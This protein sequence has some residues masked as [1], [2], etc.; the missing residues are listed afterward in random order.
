ML[1]TR[2]GSFSPAGL[3]ALD[4]WV[5]NGIVGRT[6]SG[7][8]MSAHIIHTKRNGE[9]ATTTTQ[10]IDRIVDELRDEPRIVVHFHGG[11]VDDEIGMR[12][13][14]R[15][16][17]TY[18]AAGASPIFFVWSSGLMEVVTG[19]LPE[20]FGEG[21]F[22]SI[23][24]WVTKFVLG[25]ASQAHGFAPPS[26]AD[27]WL[28]LVP[29]EPEAEALADVDVL[30]D[31]DEVS[32]EERAAFEQEVASDPELQAFSAMIAASPASLAEDEGSPFTLMTP[33][34]VG[35]IRSDAPTGAAFGPFQAVALARRAGKVVVAVV[36][37]LREHRD[38]GLYPTIIEEILRA[39]YLGQA[40]ER[41]WTAMKKE[42]ADTFEATDPVRG[43]RYFMDKLSDLVRDGHRPEITLVGH[44]T[45]AVF[46][47]N[48]L[49]RM[50]RMRSDPNDPF[51]S[52]FRV[53]NVVFLAPACR[54]EHFDNV[55]RARESTFDRFRMFTMSDEFEAKDTL[56][57]F[58]YPRSL[59]Y[60]VSGLLEAD[61][62]GQNI[63]DAPIVGM[64]RYFSMAETYDGP[65]FK[66]VRDFVSSDDSRVVWS[67]DDR[68]E[69]FASGAASHSTFDEDPEVLKSI[70]HLIAEP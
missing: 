27:L 35:E 8:N 48:F 23:R 12:V 54:F 10:D 7:G 15:L 33:D 44:S 17:P 47:D 46:I 6:N 62:E 59:L 56:V 55:L 37:R 32:E 24:K 60:F 9:L 31:I 70:K 68:G 22:Q 25:K 52:D 29:P 66:F 40:G 39:L 19:N 58:V 14:D 5:H 36:R 21:V 53:R 28:G 50:D 1:L 43:G 38:H 20:I 26:D 2:Q 34:V 18:R 4:H 64:Q 63:Y 57:P 49:A 65:E 51:P 30:D 16:D 61:E 3:Y 67:V 45:G 42:T 69:G 11:M 41:V 13:A